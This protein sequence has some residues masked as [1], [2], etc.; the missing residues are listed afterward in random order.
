MAAGWPVM[1][2]NQ[3]RGL[4][5]GFNRPPEKQGVCCCTFSLIHYNY[6]EV[7][8]FFLLTALLL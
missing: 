2:G 4:D 8:P 3:M 7:A 6:S 1:R 5:I